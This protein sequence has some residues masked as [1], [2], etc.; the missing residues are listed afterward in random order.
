MKLLTMIIA[1][2]A[3]MPVAAQ[4]FPLADLSLNC[5]ETP[6]DNAEIFTAECSND[7]YFVEI[8]AQADVPWFGVG[9]S[10]Q[11]LRELLATERG[12]PV[13]M[14]DGINL[15]EQWGQFPRDRGTF[16]V[17]GK[18]SVL[19][20]YGLS[21]PRNTG[22]FSFASSSFVED[23]RQELGG[24]SETEGDKIYIDRL[25]NAIT[26]APTYRCFV[27]NT[28]LGFITVDFFPLG[29]RHVLEE[30]DGRAVDI[31]TVR[32]HLGHLVTHFPSPV[33]RPNLLRK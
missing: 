17:P 1:M 23:M 10:L 28:S 16:E 21:K 30:T 24:M 32:A 11:G 19:C 6:T 3:A 25:K 15:L 13:E 14:I 26:L 20:Q 29:I 9:D 27:K 5:R 12:V 7:H 4:E 18:D 31:A 8:Q 2:L 22:V 33:V